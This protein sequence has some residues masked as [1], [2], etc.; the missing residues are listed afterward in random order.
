[1]SRQSRLTAGLA[2]AAL[3]LGCSGSALADEAGWYFGLS[4]GLTSADISKNDFD[5]TFVDLFSAAVLEVTGDAPDAVFVDS[6]LDDSDKGW[7][8]HV[9]YRFGRYVAAEVGYLDLGQFDYVNQVQLQVTGTP[10]IF[11]SDVR[12]Q[13]N[14]PFASVLGMF[15]INESF[16]VHVRGGILLSDTRSRL[17]SVAVEPDVP[18]SFQSLE[19]KDSDKDF[20]AGIGATWNINASYS[21]RV[22]Y[23][24]FL[25][26]G[27]DDTGET[28]VDLI[29]AALLFR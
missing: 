8:I 6:E 16:D 15:P 29:S 23:Q 4:G 12:V 26:V 13:V 9:G 20:F 17:R 2:L 14:G 18:E 11:N 3:G 28:D 24:H 27:G 22:E 21:L 19:I 7:G 10:F 5:S 1:M 25:D